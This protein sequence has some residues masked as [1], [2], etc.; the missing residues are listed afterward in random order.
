[1]KELTS[2]MANEYGD[3]QTPTSLAKTVLELLKSEGYDFEN[4]IEPTFGKGNFIDEIPEVM[5]NVRSIRGLELQPDYYN[6]AV[7]KERNDIKYELYN[8]D[9]FIFD[10]NKLF[11]KSTNNLIVGNLPWVT[12]S[13][14]SRFESK[15]IPK[16]SNIKG[17]K[18]YDALTGKSNFD[19]AEY[20][21][22]SLIN[23]ISSLNT[24]SVI[25]MLVKDIVA[26]NIIKYIPDS[27]IYPSKFSMYTINAKKE[28]NVSAD[29][30]LMVIEFN[31]DEKFDNTVGEYSLYNPDKLI[32]RFGW[33]NDSFVSDVKEYKDYSI[34]DHI[35]NWNWRSGVK[36]DA[37]KVMEL[38]RDDGKWINGLKEEYNDN[39]L[40]SKYIYPLVKSS[41][42]RKQDI[43]TKFRKYVIVTQEK[44]RED[45][46]HIEE[47]S[48]TTWNYLIKHK[49]YFD[50]RRSSIYKN[51]PE[52]SM[53]G[54]G[55]YSFK[56]Y[57]VAISGMYKSPIFSVLPP[58][59]DKPVMTDDT[60]YF[61]GFDNMT[62]AVVFAAAL[63]G[64]KAQKL[65][66]SLT[67]TD[68]KR[69]YTKDLLKRID[70]ISILKTTDI[71]EL[72]TSAFS[73]VTKNDVDSFI[74]KYDND[75]SLF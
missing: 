59:D 6:E 43:H 66:S 8:D 74:N 32:R 29:A 14:L 16:K 60:V 25:A 26:K 48:P 51:S 45:T 73:K 44:P 22:L 9:F 34:Y 49:K 47:D 40:D 30:C 67:F 58:E 1:M 57:K 63:N 23:V 53:F 75:L 17:L 61:V 21:S 37:S 52:F 72:N 42:V 71:D 62:D 38:K 41:D 4:V 24:K 39:E 15:N 33:S 35:T 55:D 19:I 20:M 69:P 50:K 3:Y 2:F 10:L 7:T 13:Q 12:A 27:N 56:P 28:F 68:S 36:H 18:G 65:I 46:S 70:V 54:I 64:D 11:D 31:G 5:S